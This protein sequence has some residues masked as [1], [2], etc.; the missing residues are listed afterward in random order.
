MSFCK[1]TLKKIDAGGKFDPI[2]D[3]FCRN[4]PNDPFCACVNPT[5]FN[6]QKAEI[7]AEITDATARNEYLNRAKIYCT[8]PPCFGGEAYKDSNKDMRCENINICTSNI[9]TERITALQGSNITFNAE[10]NIN[11]EGDNNTNTEEK[12]SK[13]YIYIGGGVSISLLLLIAVIAIVFIL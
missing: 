1:D 12:S 2:V 6:Q 8:Y 11:G 5:K 9:S 13:K 4:K 3:N 10:C 7:A